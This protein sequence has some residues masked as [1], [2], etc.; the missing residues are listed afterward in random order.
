MC[1]GS[2][3]YHPL[4]S[5]LSVTMNLKKYM[6]ADGFSLVM[7]EHQC[8]FPKEYLKK[9]IKCVMIFIISWFCFDVSVNVRVVQ[10]RLTFLDNLDVFLLLIL[11]PN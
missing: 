5:Y 3:S 10:Y 4:R 7:R 8:F 1:N 6:Y 2:L 11:V 9:M